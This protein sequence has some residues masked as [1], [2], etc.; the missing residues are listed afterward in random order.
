MAWF[1]RGMK[2]VFT[3]FLQLL[4]VPHTS[5]YSDRF[6]RE[7][8]YK[9]SLFGLSRML[10]DYGVD[11]LALRL[12]RDASELSELEAPFIA[13][14]NNEFV[15]VEKLSSARVSYY[16]RGKSIE[17][18]IEDFLTAWSGVVL[19]AEKTGH[20]KE[21]GYGEHLKTEWFDRGEKLIFFAVLL[22]LLFVS[23]FSNEQF[24][25]VYLVLSSVFNLAGLYVSW[26]LLLKQTG[27]QTEFGDKVCS[28]FKKSSYNDVL[29]T[30][31]AKLFGIVGWSEIGV[32]YFISNLLL[33][34]CAGSLAGYYV[35][36]SVMALPFTVWSFCYQKFKIRI[37]CPLCL[38]VLGILWANFSVNV[39]CDIRMAD[40]TGIPLLLAGCVYLLPLLSVDILCR[41]FYRN[42]SMEDAQYKL[43]SLKANKDVFNALLQKGEKYP[44]DQS[45]SSVCW[46][47][48]E[49]WDT[50][51]V[52]TNPHCDPCAALHRK[53]DRLLEKGRD[54]FFIRYVFTSF[55]EPLSISAKFLIYSYLKHDEATFL[56]ILDKWYEEGKYRKESFFREYGFEPD[57]QVDE[58]YAR[59]YDFVMKNKIRSTPTILFNGHK[60][61]DEYMLED[62][63]HIV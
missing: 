41:M 53:L 35:L 12:D 57:R 40:M 20:S 13:F 14:A 18:P 26:S 25:A 10:S 3:R 34:H 49:A 58:E 62:L 46:G 4:E 17:L 2:N 8:P 30:P 5:E 60:K 44:V 55:N 6:Y 19:L 39:L 36:A 21:P 24:P 45:V 37:W 29:S 28:L 16:W 48:K 7:Y 47:N 38:V 50:I 27:M 63:L 11:N 54:K 1:R 43:N 52:I 23:F 9:D 61:P 59:H 15:L 32:S 31:A 51:T 33:L 22:F 56:A 42:S